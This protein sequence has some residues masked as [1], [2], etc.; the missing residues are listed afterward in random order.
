MSNDKQGTT[1]INHEVSS[2]FTRLT[3]LEG[4]VIK[5]RYTHGY[6]VE[7]GWKPLKKGGRLREYTAEKRERMKCGRSGCEKEVNHRVPFSTTSKG[8]Q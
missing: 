2:T 3:G 7:V 6:S 4:K 5:G 1:S 8:L